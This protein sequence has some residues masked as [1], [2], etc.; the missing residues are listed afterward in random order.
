MAKIELNHFVRKIDPEFRDITQELLKRLPNGY[1]LD[2]NDGLKK[3]C[4]CENLKC[5]DFLLEKDGNLYFTEFSDLNS[6]DGNIREKIKQQIN[7]CEQVKSC[8]VKKDYPKVLQNIKTN[9]FVLKYKD[10]LLLLLSIKNDLEPDTIFHENTDK[11][12]F[13]IVYNNKPN[14][15]LVKYLDLLKSN[16]ISSLPTKLFNRNNFKIQNL[17]YFISNF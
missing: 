14:T 7:C 10:T 2:N 13:L 9:D 3:H 11:W 8:P 5:V 1:L 4:N 15:D 6:E 17:D 16:I 12:H